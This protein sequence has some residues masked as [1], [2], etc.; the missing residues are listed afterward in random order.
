MARQGGQA[1]RKPG[2]PDRA[3]AQLAKPN[4]ASSADLDKS[5]G[6]FRILWSLVESPISLYTLSFLL[7]AALLLYGLYQD[8]NSPL[9]YTDIDY[10][11]FTDAARYI[12]QGRSPYDRETYRY[13]PLLA[14][15]LLPTAWETKSYIWN[16]ALF[17]SGKI[18]FAMADLVAGWLIELVLRMGE[19]G[20]GNEMSPR[21]ARRYAAI[22]L[23]NPMVATISTRGSSE[24]L[25]AVLVMALLWAV[26]ARKVALAGVFLGFGVHFKIYPFI[27]APA[28]IWW[29]DAER[30]ERAPKRSGSKTKKQRS[31]LSERVR[32]FLTQ[33]RI[34]LAMTSLGTFMFLNLAMYAM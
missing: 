12:H 15:L 11:V 8:A 16:V 2:L 30:M 18:L 9:K 20:K 4:A 31:I 23:L 13:T 10:M 19:D 14:W 34:T 6:P 32:D 22:W 27:Y 24:G 33:D 1:Q 17:S 21:K 5:P 3:T 26:L 25:L 7:R 29:M 28:I